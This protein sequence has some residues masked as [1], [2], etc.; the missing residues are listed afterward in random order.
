[1][2]GVANYYG[3]D[4]HNTDILAV[5][6]RVEEITP[7]QGLLEDAGIERT[8]ADFGFVTSWATLG[9]LTRW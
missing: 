7:E 6:Y 3:G 2:T 9:R 1:M 5:E 4:Y 8:I